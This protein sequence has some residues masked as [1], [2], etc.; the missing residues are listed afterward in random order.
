MA[1]ALKVGPRT[2]L[3]VSCTRVD[4]NPG[5]VA[6][7]PTWT[8]SNPALVAIRADP[9]APEGLSVSVACVGPVDPAVAAP[10]VA[11][12]CAGRVDLGTG[13]RLIQTWP[14]DMQPQAAER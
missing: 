14:F 12:S 10:V 8:S 13:L 6:S 2:R 9:A 5:A 11:I 7:P 4:G 1:L 3:S